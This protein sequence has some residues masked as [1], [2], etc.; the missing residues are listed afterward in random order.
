MTILGMAPTRSNG[1]ALAVVI[2]SLLALGTVVWSPDSSTQAAAGSITLPFPAPLRTTPTDPDGAPARM[3]ASVLQPAPE[4]ALRREAAPAVIKVAVPKPKESD[5]RWRP[6]R[7]EKAP[8]CQLDCQYTHN[9]E[10]R[11]CGGYLTAEQLALEGRSAPL[12]GC[13]KALYQTLQACMRKC[14]ITIPDLRVVP[15]PRGMN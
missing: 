2:G 10:L 8:S 14:G 11:Y 4:V 13:R 5:L 12:P 15:A 6:D 1:W 3:R 9:D 7:T